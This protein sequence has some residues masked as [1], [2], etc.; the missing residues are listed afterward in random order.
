[1]IQNMNQSNHFLKYIQEEELKKWKAR[2][3]L[4]DFEREMVNLQAYT[5][6]S[7]QKYN[8]YLYI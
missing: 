5:D 3:L 8:Q 4:Q 7:T 1:M 6:V 2:K